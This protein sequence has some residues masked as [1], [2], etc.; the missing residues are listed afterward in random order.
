MSKRK[1]IIKMGTMFGV[2]LTIA[3]SILFLFVFQTEAAGFRIATLDQLN[4]IM[5]VGLLISILVFFLLIRRRIKADTTKRRL[6]FWFIISIGMFGMV[7]YGL[8]LQGGNLREVNQG[9]ILLIMMIGSIGLFGVS[10]FF[11]FLEIFL[12]KKNNEVSSETN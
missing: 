5:I 3:T 2:L 12:G 1:K 4:T 9:V 8:V 11:N 10:I 7:A 6:L